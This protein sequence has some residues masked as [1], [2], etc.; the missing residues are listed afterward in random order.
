MAVE[1]KEKTRHHENEFENLDFLCK[2]RDQKLQKSV[3]R[4]TDGK[5]LTKA[6]TRDKEKTSAASQVS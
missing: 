3:K 1:L 6:L 2:N 4:N 5:M